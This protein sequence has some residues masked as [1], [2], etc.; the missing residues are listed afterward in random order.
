MRPHLEYAVGMWSPSTKVN[1]NA[2]EKVQRR[3]T[4]SVKSLKKKPYEERLK[5]LGLMNLEDRRVRGDLI[6]LFKIINRHEEINLMNGVNWAS[7][8]KFN[9][10]RKNDKRILREITKR[11]S[12]RCN[13][14]TNRIVSVWNGLSQNVMD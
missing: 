4:K 5:S 8:L 10:R 6:Q 3:A 2:I 12:H 11:G 14:L 1:I 13:F 9:L 7:S